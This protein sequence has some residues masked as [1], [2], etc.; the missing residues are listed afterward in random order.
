MPDIEIDLDAS[1]AETLAEMRADPDE[2][3]DDADDEVVVSEEESEPTE[4]KSRDEKGR[5][6]AKEDQPEGADEDAVEAAGQSDEVTSVV[7]PVPISPPEHANA[8]PSWTAEARSMW[9]EVPPRIRAEVYK[10][11]QDSA[12]GVDQM[13]EKATFGERMDKLLAPYR[14][15]IAAEGST[16]EGAVEGLMNTAYLLRQ[17]QVHQK[18]ELAIQMAQQYG[19]LPQLVEFINTKGQNVQQRGQIDQVLAPLQQQIGQLESRLK[20][21]EDAERQSQE[22]SLSQEVDGFINASEPDGTLKHPYFWNVRD[23]MVAMLN[24]GAAGNYE[25]AYDLAVRSHPETRPIVE[26]EQERQRLTKTQA[27]TKARAEKAKKAQTVNIRK[28]GT[29]GATGSKPTGSI[30]DTLRETLNSIRGRAS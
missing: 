2:E 14:P 21:K 9:K 29:H 6:A 15:I 19:F 24:A 26:A 8:P 30:D 10:R 13:R 23:M 20:A 3:M 4:A 17:G 28:T 16:P 25:E 22:S 18:V 12:R 7:P 1:M 5:F 11:E 27:E